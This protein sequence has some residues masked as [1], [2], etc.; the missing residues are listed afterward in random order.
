M[1]HPVI[2]SAVRTPSGKLLGSLSPLRAPELGAVA[3]GAA[4]E[5]AGR[6]P[7]D[8]DEV[9]MG[10]VI[11]AGSGQ[12]PAR[13]AALGADLPPSVAAMTINKVCGSSLK[14]AQRLVEEG[15]DVRTLV[16]LIDRQEGGREM[17]EL[18]GFKLVSLFTRA[19]FE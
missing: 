3:V 18:A 10:Q 19:D 11:Q 4:I 12:N 14:A 6:A 5:R 1:R 8:V 7:E 13:Q 16:T 2:V 9:I 17:I 15:Y